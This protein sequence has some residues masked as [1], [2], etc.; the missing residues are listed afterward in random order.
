MTIVVKKPSC[1]RINE[2]GTE[3][4]QVNGIKEVVARHQPKARKKE[5]E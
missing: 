3:R 2:E 1:N 5:G 4:D